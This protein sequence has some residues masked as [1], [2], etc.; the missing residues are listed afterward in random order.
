MNILV[1]GDIARDVFINCD[2]PRLS[3]EKPVPI[4]VPYSIRENEGMAANVAANIEALASSAKVVRLFPNNPSVKT[5]YVDRGSNQ[6]FLRVDQDQHHEPIQAQAVVKVLDQF[7]VDAVV[8]SD[9]AKGFLNASNMEVILTSCFEKGIPT[10]VD[11]KL[12][13]GGWSE[14]AFVIKINAKEYAAQLTAGVIAPHAWCQNLIETRGRAGMVLYE[15]AGPE[16]KVAYTAVTKD[17]GVR[18]VVGCGDSV[19][20][21]LVV[22]YLETKDLKRAMDFATKVGTYAASQPGVT[23]VKREDV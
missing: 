6:H 23:V 19:L 10:F 11:T 3:P 15:S 17:T 5:R 20:A 9:Y 16:P 12:R 18:D 22:G 7:T 4:V 14:D 1:I 8:L 21:G 13:L 2:T